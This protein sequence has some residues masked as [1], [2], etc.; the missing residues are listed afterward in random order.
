MTESSTTHLVLI[1]SYN[2]GD[3]VRDTV[4]EARRHWS[5]VW[6][7]VDGSTDG[8]TQWLRQEAAADPGLR[9]IVLPRNQGKGAAVL[10]GLELAAA[11]GFTHVLTMDSDGQHPAGLIAPFMAVSQRD[12]QAMVLGR[13]VFDASAPKVRVYGR[14]ISNAW[15]NLETLWAGIGDSLYGFRVYPIAPLRAVM[16]GQRWM[17][18]FDFDPEVVVRM[19]WRG[20]RP[21]NLDA[22]VRYF[23]ADEGGVS[24]F[25]YLRDNVLLSWMHMRLLFGFLARLPLLAC[26]RL[27][28]RR[29]AGPRITAP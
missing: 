18:R 20:V 11:E 16:Y 5:P 13:P 14:R 3:K 8:S 2:P 22:P 23:S 25:N 28:A 15:A 26:R 9:V 24:H 10:R 19:C 1:P 6:V 12:P 21:L 7:V 17:R 27:R 4:R 29:G